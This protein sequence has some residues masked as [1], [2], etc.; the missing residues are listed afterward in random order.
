VVQQA[1]ETRQPK[2]RYV[3]GFPLSG[4]LAIHLGGP[5]WDLIVRQMFKIQRSQRNLW[6]NFEE[7]QEK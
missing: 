6:V 7:K 4:R 3:A 2:A 5:V 1:I